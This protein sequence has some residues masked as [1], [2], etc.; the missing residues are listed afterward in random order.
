MTL[1]SLSSANQP[2]RI[3]DGELRIVAELVDVLV[4]KAVDA[5]TERRTPRAGSPVAAAIAR[6]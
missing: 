1:R 5:Q 3:S 2:L 4:P 6:A